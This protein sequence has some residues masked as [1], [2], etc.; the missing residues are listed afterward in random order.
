MDQAEKR[1][2]LTVETRKEL[3]HSMEKPFSFY[4]RDKNK[5]SL[6]LK[7][8]AI[9]EAQ[10]SEKMIQMRQKA[11][12][13]SPRSRLPRHIYER[14]MER[15]AEDELI[16]E[17]SRRLRA[18]KLLNSAALPPGMEL[19]ELERKERLKDRAID[20]SPMPSQ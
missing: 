4:Y 20:S 11:S 6:R 10:I 15:F 3:L 19:R 12:I 16:R 7:R 17:V 8:Q 9:R 14:R 13:L 2:K 5:E 18:Q 1:R